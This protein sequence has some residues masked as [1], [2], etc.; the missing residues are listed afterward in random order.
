MAFL[1]SLAYSGTNFAKNA[2]HR[3]SIL[4]CN[5]MSLI[6]CAL[7]LLL[8]VAYFYWYGWNLVTQAIPVVALFSLLPLLLNRSGLL[9]VSRILQCLL[10]PIAA[11]GVSIY[12]KKTYYESQEELDYFTF[13]F[14]MLASCVFPVVFFSFQEKKLLFV[15]SSIGF[16]LLMLHDP[17]H[18]FFKVPYQKDFLKAHN[19]YFTNVVIA[20][21]YG[22]LMGAVFFLRKVMENSEERATLL[23]GEL[24]RTNEELKAKH[25]EIESQNQ[26]IT[27]QTE[28]LN[29]SQQK[30]QDANMLIEE[31]KELLLKMNRH[32]SS[33]LLE[34]N[35]EL[36]ATNNELIKHNNELRQFSYTVSHNLRGPVASLSGLIN[37]METDDLSPESV[38]IYHHIRTSI[39]RLEAVIKDLS[40]IIDIRNDVFHIRKKINLS[41]EINEIV[42][43]FRKEVENQNI[44]FRVDLDQ[45]R[46]MYSVKPMI[47]SILFNLIGNAIKYRAPDRRSEI[48]IASRKEDNFFVLEVTDNGLGIDLKNHK[49]NLFRL[50]K[51]FHYHT[52]GKGLGLYLVKL[53]AEILGGNINVESEINRYTTFTVRIPIPENIQ[54]QILYKSDCA[55]IF[56]DAQ[57]NSTGVVWEGP[58]SS[59][60]YRQVFL[61]CLEFVKTYNTPN[62][63]ADISRQGYINRDD[64]TWMF[65]NVMSEA[66]KYGLKKIAAIKPLRKDPKL[67]EYLN[68]INVS[69]SSLGIEQEFFSNFEEATSWIQQQNEMSS[70]E[71]MI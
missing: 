62:Y 24:N 28:N 23:I 56:Y 19:Y 45:C 38:R 17:L 6:V 67:K 71:H 20:V 18:S 50:Y 68:G 5:V 35:K 69:L 65:Q 21:T 11:L 44:L 7:G 12:A 43:G 40:Q 63:I 34:I 1:R 13:R 46:E 25:S 14:I 30:L 61:K 37:L 64:Q 26:E 8:F 47:D 15:I 29:L 10:I 9:A 51:R 58:V 59:E 39:Q 31:Q 41:K 70:F 2:S 4:L 3:R 33:E 27:A 55:T 32:L 57:I 60:Q 49:Q 22:I 42:Q 16:L 36:T 48:L 53:Q 52:E 54:H 66:A